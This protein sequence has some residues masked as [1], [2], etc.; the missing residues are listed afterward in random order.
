MEIKN[1]V[2]KLGN[3][4]GSK[5]DPTISQPTRPRGVFLLFKILN[6]NFNK[7]KPIFITK[8]LS[9]TKNPNIN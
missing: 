8:N 2:T 5:K 7:F 9:L 4:L 6:F 1:H 3:E